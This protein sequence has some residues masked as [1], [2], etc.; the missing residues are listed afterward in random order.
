VWTKY[1]LSSEQNAKTFLQDS[2]RDSISMMDIQK[3]L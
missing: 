1:C 3:N 2:A